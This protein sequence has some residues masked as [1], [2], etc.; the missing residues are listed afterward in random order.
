MASVASALALSCSV[1]AATPVVGGYVLLDPVDGPSKLRALA[2]NA[3]TIPINR[4]FLSFASPTLA[5]VPGSNTLQHVGLNYATSGDYGFAD[6]KTQVAV[7]QAGGVEVF[8]SVGGWDYG[9]FP[10][11]YTYYSIAS[12]G[13]TDNSN[14]YEITNF[15]GL[16]NCT[17][18]NLWC[19]T[20]EP[21]SA[22]TTLANFAVFPEPSYSSTWQAAQKYV[23]ATAKGD[24]PV[25][26]PNLNPGQQWLD[27]NN[28]MV[29]TV[30]GDSYFASVNRDPYQDLVYLAKDL[31]LAGV[32]IDY[33][34]MW[35]ADYFRSGPSDG[36]WTNY[37]T[38]YKYSAIMKDVLLNIAAIDPTLKL[39]TAAAAAGGDSSAWWGGNLKNIWYYV[40]KFYPDLYNAIATGGGV[41]IMSYDL[42]D[43]EASFECPTPT[44]C[45]L[46]QQVKYYMDTY[47]ANGMAATVGYEI[48]TPAYPDP[49]H[50]P[51]HALP[52]IQSELTAIL[53][54][55]GSGGGFFW[56]LFKPADAATN[57]NVTSAAQQICVAALG[58]STSRCHGSIPLIGGPSSTSTSA[59]A[60]ATIIATTTAT[61]TA[62]VV[63]KTI[64]VTTSASTPTPT[65]G[66]CSATAWS[67]TTAYNSGAVVSYSGHQY[68]AQWWTQNNIPTAG[69]PWTDNGVCGGSSGGGGGSGGSCSG[70]N[71]WSSAT[72]YSSGAK[73]RVPEASLDN[74]LHDDPK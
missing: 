9:C 61:T 42:S 51:T 19:Y 65:T 44:T 5:Y 49:A 55:Y 66:T 45:S 62:T 27:T 2:Q 6:I 15:G 8:L 69:A 70:V 22:G 11:M 63:S 68:T 14:Y 39:S 56:E 47:S 30:P 18:A 13:P 12:Y 20:C 28:S 35:H 74:S 23:I 34:E 21:Q 33:E 71:A 26:H 60:T 25:F 40:H 17:S 53:K 43:N 54:S 29:V 50:D 38:V 10:Y 72:A 58:S 46:S 52:L 48:G 41:N 57:V 24:Y 31:G 36:P 67:A 64:T 32:D 3:A 4:L 37:Q 59:T 73:V 7:L 16:A 1:M